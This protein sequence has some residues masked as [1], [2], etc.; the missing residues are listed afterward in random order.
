LSGAFLKRSQLFQCSGDL[1][2]QALT[3]KE[4]PL[5]KGRAIRERKTIQ[6]RSTHQ[7]YRLSQAGSALGAVLRMP[8][9][10]VCAASFD[11]VSKES[12]IQFVLAEGIELQIKASREQV[13]L[14]ILLGFLKIFLQ[15]RPGDAQAVLRCG[16]GIFGP[17]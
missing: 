17:Q 13:G 14:R 9:M 11:Q 6:K 2:L 16:S 5:V 8:G 7:F 3:F 15:L 1:L 12:Y 10:R 4:E